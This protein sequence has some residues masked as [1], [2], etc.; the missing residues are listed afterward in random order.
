ML[1]LRLRLPHSFCGRVG[2]K[3]ART[4]PSGV[5]PGTT[6]AKMADVTAEIKTPAADAPPKAAETLAEDLSKK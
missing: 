5:G 1:S 3:A 4:S 2:S 6:A